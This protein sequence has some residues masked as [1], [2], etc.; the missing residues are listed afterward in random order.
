MKSKTLT[1]RQ[2][3]GSTLALTLVTTGILGFLLVAYLSL[4][5][6]QNI[7]NMRSQAW[8]QAIPVIEAGIEDA[9]THLN[10]HGV[11]NLTCDNWNA[12]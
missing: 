4:V 6:S 11:S 7:S 3:E 10:T 5:R 2:K 9:L 8:N 1:S 12:P